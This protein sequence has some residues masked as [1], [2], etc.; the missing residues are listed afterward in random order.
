MTTQNNNNNNTNKLMSEIEMGHTKNEGFSIFFLVVVY[1]ELV[2][3]RFKSSSLLNLFNDSIMCV[4]FFF[5][6]NFAKDDA[7]SLIYILCVDCNR[8]CNVF[9]GEKKKSLKLNHFLT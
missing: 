4:L 9:G 6:L 8:E 1:S 3:H 7:S 5:Q 2:E